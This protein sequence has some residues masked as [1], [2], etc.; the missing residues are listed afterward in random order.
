M[1]SDRLVTLWTYQSWNDWRTLRITGRLRRDDA[2]QAH[3]EP[4]LVEPYEWMRTEMRKRI[5][6]YGGAWPIW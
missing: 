5:V 6:G 4:Y 3:I 1:E 2:H